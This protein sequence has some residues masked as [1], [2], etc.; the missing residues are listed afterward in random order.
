M[1][2]RVLIAIGLIGGLIALVLGIALD[3]TWVTWVVYAFWACMVVALVVGLLRR[4]RA[5][6]PVD[7][8]E[9]LRDIYSGRASREYHP[10]EVD[11][12]AQ[13]APAPP[14][15]PLELPDEQR[16]PGRLEG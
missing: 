10:A 3:A 2:K 14:R 9:P 15:D 4:R 7:P 1:V 8:M 11:E 16:P 5:T 13:I 12:N 6:S